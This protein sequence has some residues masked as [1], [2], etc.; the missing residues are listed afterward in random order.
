MSDWSEWTKKPAGSIFSPLSA[1]IGLF[2]IMIVLNVSAGYF[3]R[4]QSAV[5]AWHV[6]LNFDGFVS[7]VALFSQHLFVSNAHATL[8]VDFSKT[9]M[10]PKLPFLFFFLSFFLSFLITYCR[11]TAVRA[12]TSFENQGKHV[13]ITR[14]SRCVGGSTNPNQVWSR[15]VLAGRLCG[16]SIETILSYPILSYQPS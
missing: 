10:I 11:T 14:H 13:E 4:K 3:K 7:L 5:N 9:L 16:Q 15:N 8:A 6:L 12:S 1:L 2:I